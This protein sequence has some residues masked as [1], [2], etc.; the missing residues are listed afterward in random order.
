MT[1][2]ITSVVPACYP[3]SETMVKFLAEERHIPSALTIPLDLDLAN[4]SLQDHINDLRLNFLH[5]YWSPL[6]KEIADLRIEAEEPLRSALEG[7]DILSTKTFIDILYRK[8]PSKEGK[9][10]VSSM[11]VSRWRGRGFIRTVEESD[12][13]IA[14][15]TALAVLMMRLADATRQKGWLPPGAHTNEPYMYVWR[16]DSPDQPVIPCG[17]PLDNTIPN[18]AFLFTPFKFLGTLY[19]DHWFALGDL[20]SVRFA[21]TI[22]VGN[23]LLWNLTEEEIRL[24]NPSIEPLGRGILDTFALQARD[25]LANLVL[26]NLATQE[27]TRQTTPF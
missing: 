25:N 23:K 27:L 19:P 4:L 13:Q 20:G 22:Q 14:A 11:T 7:K 8:T 10:K 15:E 24:W 12:E 2:L 3:L 18:H 5:H 16:K 26:L 21:G 17:L 9:T 6:I 1:S